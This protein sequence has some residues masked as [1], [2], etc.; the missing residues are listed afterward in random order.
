LVRKQRRGD[1]LRDLITD[2]KIPLELISRE[3]NK[4]VYIGIIW[5]G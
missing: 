1:H 5:I 4:G 3:E 2:W